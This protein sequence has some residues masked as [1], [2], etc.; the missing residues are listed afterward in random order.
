MSAELLSDFYP[1]IRTV[2]R[3]TDVARLGLDRE[4]ERPFLR[5]HVERVAERLDTPYVIIDVLL[6]DAQ[7]F[8]AELGP[9]PEFLQEAGGTPL[10][11]AFC[12]P[13]VT[14]RAPRTVPDLATDPLFRDNPLVKAGGVRSYAGAPLVSQSG[15]VLGG[16][17]GLDVEPR[18]FSQGDLVFLKEIADE[19]VV[20]L[21]ERAD[22]P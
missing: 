20:L 18:P 7:V 11:W 22:R 8:L 16:V 10:E 1:A 2:D 19:V 14:E 15:H 13:L 9:I 6:N 5:P 21:E 4:A 17:C 12:Q 3:L